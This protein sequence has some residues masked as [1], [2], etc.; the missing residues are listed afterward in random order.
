[1]TVSFFPLCVHVVLT[2]TRY[3]LNYIVTC[4]L[5]AGGKMCHVHIVIVRFQMDD[6]KGR[7][8]GIVKLF[9][10]PRLIHACQIDI[11]GWE[12]QRLIHVGSLIIS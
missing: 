8:S 3:K 1:M 12:S 9:V 7:Y 10:Y 4:R 6:Y 5:Y 2:H 11:F